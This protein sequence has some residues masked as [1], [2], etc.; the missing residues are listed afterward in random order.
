LDERKD[1]RDRVWYVEARP[2]GDADGLA[3]EDAWSMGSAVLVEIEQRDEPRRVRRYL[4][5]CA[6]VVRQKGRNPEHWWGPVHGEILC[7]R[8]GQGYTRTYA[9]RRCGEHPDIFAAKVSAL[10]PC[11]GEPG[12]LPPELR[13]PP[14]D[15][16]LLEIDDP[17][18]QLAGKPLRWSE[19]GA[20]EDVF[21]VGYPGG[22]GLAAHPGGHLWTTGT[23][24]DNVATGP[25][26][27]TRAPEPGMLRLEGVDETRPG[28]SGGGIFD[29][30]GALVGLHRSADDAALQRNAIAI[31]TIRDALDT[32]RNA[33]PTTP[34]REP[35]P[36]FVRRALLALALLAIVGLGVWR[37]RAADDCALLVEVA[38]A[39]PARVFD[40]TRANGYAESQLLSEAGS[41][42]VVLADMQPRERWS[43]SIRYDDAATAPVELRGCPAA[44][45]RHALT[46]SD[47]VTLRPQ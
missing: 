15:W 12:P 26:H 7:W 20:G 23:P 5:T 21:I 17:A 34:T 36:V 29:A 6:H 41:A 27:Q 28:M 4:L 33:Y 25:F 31:G 38:S 43:F 32:R 37:W 30:H 13:F 47:H 16:V 1:I 3:P 45:T 8:R 11:G 19:I 22:A 46:G 35:V 14:H 10:S 9:G 44:P 42:A 39:A 18:F 24:V 2:C 40:A